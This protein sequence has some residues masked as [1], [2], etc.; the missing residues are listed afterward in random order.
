VTRSERWLERTIE[1][2][3][4]T[5]GNLIRSGSRWRRAI[6]IVIGASAICCIIPVILAWLLFGKKPKE[7]T[8]EPARTCPT[9][10]G[11]MV[12]RSFASLHQC[13]LAYGHDGYCIN[14]RGEAMATRELLPEERRAYITQMDNRLIR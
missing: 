6:G 4:R 11:Y 7:E 14:E 12:G 10:C 5:S 3:G 1:R 9:V 2:I 13:R 8:E